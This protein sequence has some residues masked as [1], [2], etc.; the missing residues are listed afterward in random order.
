AQWIR[1]LLY[2]STQAVVATSNFIGIRHGLCS[3]PT[4]L[5]KP[6]RGFGERIADGGDRSA[7]GG[8]DQMLG[9]WAQKFRVRNGR[10]LCEPSFMVRGLVGAVASFDV[11]IAGDGWDPTSTSAK[12]FLP[13]PAA[14]PAAHELGRA[15]SQFDGVELVGGKMLE[16]PDL[17]T[18]S[19]EWSR[20]RQ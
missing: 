11:D 19:R 15:L 18:V 6:D 3:L 8:V 13:L 9:G 7:D 20:L 1:R 2:H 12:R 4:L 10:G 14:L 16:N 5:V 17:D